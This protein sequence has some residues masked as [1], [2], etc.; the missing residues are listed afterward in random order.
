MARTN[1]NEII[2]RLRKLGFAVQSH[3]P[4]NQR[5]YQVGLP[6]N[7]SAFQPVSPFM[8]ASELKMFYYGILAGMGT[9]MRF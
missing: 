7:G 3:K 5:L 1:T 9:P 8:T 4:G 2:K 6:V